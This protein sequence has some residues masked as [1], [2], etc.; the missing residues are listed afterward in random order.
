MKKHSIKY[1]Q[2][3]ISNTGIKPNITP[4]LFSDSIGKSFVGYEEFECGVFLQQYFVITSIKDGLYYSVNEED[5][6]FYFFDENGCGINQA[7][8]RMTFLS[9]GGE[10]P[11][12][13]IDILHNWESPICGHYEDAPN[14]REMTTE[15]KQE[16]WLNP[17]EKAYIEIVS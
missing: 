15:E 2:K 7:A 13:E 10:E 8:G 16:R 17:A 12:R 3:Y 6:E 9:M 1:V 5:E 14:K 4:I 11:K